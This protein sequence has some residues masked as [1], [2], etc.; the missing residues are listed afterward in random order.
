M[1][2]NALTAT[3]LA[4]LMAVSLS[5]YPSRN[6]IM[7]SLQYSYGPKDAWLKPLIIPFHKDVFNLEETGKVDSIKAIVKGKTSI[8]I[9]N[10]NGSL[11]IKTDGDATASA[12][13]TLQWWTVGR[14]LYAK[15][16]DTGKLNHVIITNDGNSKLG[17]V[18][19]IDP[20]NKI[21]LVEVVCYPLA[22]Y[23]A[24]YDFNKDT[25][26]YRSK[27]YD[28]R[29]YCLGRDKIL[30]C[31]Y[32]THDYFHHS[33]D[34]KYTDPYMKKFSRSP[35][36]DALNRLKLSIYPYDKNISMEH[37]IILGTA[38]KKKPALIDYSSFIV[39]WDKDEKNVSV[40]EIETEQYC[41]VSGQCGFGGE[42]QLSG[43][44]KMGQNQCALESRRL[45]QWRRGLH[46]RPRPGAPGRNLSSPP[47]R[48]VLV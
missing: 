29:L 26:T 43:D 8:I 44:G 1:R 19:L 48:H 6:A 18:A 25:I 12:N 21:F 22:D 5:C 17:M 9:F 41:G 20:V 27:R 28:G 30:L 34:W 7:E 11:T 13:D 37:R 15:D 40:R 10:D 16:T 31:Q 42:T 14:G 3:L 38:K 24:L 39:R 33:I 45:L 46:L 2:T 4:L 23:I 35:L 36:T 32:I 47:V